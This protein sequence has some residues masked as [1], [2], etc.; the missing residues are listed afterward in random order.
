MK[1]KRS[2]DLVAS[3]TTTSKGADRTDYVIQTND[4]SRSSDTFTDDVQPVKKVAK[5]SKQS[6][7]AKTTGTNVQASKNGNFR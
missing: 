2:D 6:A 4:E 1:R 7:A 5:L 3:D